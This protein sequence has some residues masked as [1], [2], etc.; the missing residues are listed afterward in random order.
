MKRILMSLLTLAAVGGLAIGA[1]SAFFSDTETST[2]NTIAAGQ[3]D[4]KVDSTAHYAGL[5]CTLVPD[6]T[7]YRWA[8]D[9][10]GSFVVTT[11]TRPE[12]LNQ[13]CVG[14]FS[15]QDLD[16]ELSD[17][18]FAL[19]DVKPGDEG[20]NTISLHVTDND[21]WARARL[22]AVSDL[23]NSCPEPELDVETLCDP[24]GTGELDSAM[25]LTVWLD[26]GA[27][28]GFQ[29][30]NPAPDAVIDSTEGDNI[31]QEA[32]EPL[33][34]IPG[35]IDGSDVVYPFASYLSTVYTSESCIDTDGNTNYGNCHGLASDGRFVGSAVYYFGLGWTVN[36]S[37]GNEIQTDSLTA[38]IGFEVEQHRNNP[39]PFL[40]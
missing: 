25:T 8:D 4:L 36:E 27:T 15:E 20:E 12:L 7:E 31:R 18:F 28:P 22:S 35:F 2:G 16:A 37:A 33:V 3:L 11:S 38:N 9:V 34:N 24:N 23:D 5:E 13:L 6:S 40:P 19:T 30:N 29:N 17:R 10:T 1:T 21:A 14:T 39:T 32:D 26:Q